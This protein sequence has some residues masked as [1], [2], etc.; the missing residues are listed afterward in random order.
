MFGGILQVVAAG[1]AW[2]LSY[3]AGG[4]HLLL[5]LTRCLLVGVP[6]WTILYL[7]LKQMR[8]AAGEALETQELRRAQEAGASQAIF[9]VD[10][11]AL[12]LEQDRVR[13]MVRWLLPA[14]TV[15]ISLVLLIGHL[16]SWGLSVEQALDEEFFTSAQKSLRMP[17]VF[18]V[19]LTAFPC[20]L[21]SRY[22]LAVARLPQWGLV[23]AGAVCMSGC[24]LGCVLAA[25]GL[26]AAG[27][28]EW[29]EGLAAYV[30]G[31][32]LLLLGLEFA[33]NFILDLYRP[34]TADEVPRPAFDSRLLGMVGE[35]G[36][37]AKSLADAMNYQFGFQVSSTWFYQLLQRWLFPIT[38]V[39]FAVMLLL[40][41]V[42]VVDADERALIER[43]GKQVKTP[44]GALEPGL[45]LKWPFPIDIVYRAP[46]K[47]ISE[48]VI[49]E[50]GDEHDE[51]DE[52]GEHDHKAVLWTEPH[53]YVP[54][55]MLLVAS[56]ELDERSA[57]Q[58]ARP[59]AARASEGTESVAVS[60]LM[61][62]VPIE[63]RIKDLKKYLYNYN[64]PRGVLESIAYRHLSDYAARIDLDALMGPG[65]EA[66]NHDLRRV[67]Q[68]R[69]N[70]L[71]MGIELVFV[72]LREAHPPPTANVAKEFQAVVAAQT[73][74]A[75]VINA[76]HGEA[77]RILI[78]AAG[79]EAQAIALDKA[80]RERDDLDPD[81]AEG[82]ASRARVEELLMGDPARSIAPVSGEA[83]AAIAQA[84]GAASDQISRAAA[85]AFM[86]GTEVAAYRAAPE[87]YKQRKALD[88]YTSI[89]HIRK[90]LI[91]GD[92]SNVIIEYDVAKEAGLD[93]ILDEGVAKQ[94]EKSNQ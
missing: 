74:M 79:T 14:G 37:F 70:E 91:V 49:G 65:R 4:S 53:D 64:D 38:V 90:Y 84:R 52:H 57:G 28:V 88:V 87:L 80:I 2:G 12:L 19:L 30:I 60:L 93:Q 50:A 94:G 54:E 72:G 1:V 17:L 16:A 86:F 81:S 73:S 78:S 40:T 48:L 62:S 26:M 20:F 31:M 5:A 24:A 18:C 27:T 55:L 10:D 11:E 21:Y 58:A 22:A 69:L 7:L 6:I 23:R 3:W 9:E 25:L 76:A 82:L 46:V 61:V 71:D 75:A 63:Y 51:H 8:R 85:K 41:T 13:W 45:H 89:S 66:F 77:R 39:A 15:L 67:I 43:F 42:V 83:A 35:P 29:A 47:R 32:A 68:D 33:V 92:R 59:P 56:P 34:R 44:T 36:G